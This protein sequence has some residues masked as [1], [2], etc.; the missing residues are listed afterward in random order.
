MFK[1]AIAMMLSVLT[2]TL[3]VSGCSGSASIE[4]AAKAGKF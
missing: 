1:R 4:E 3:A 2:V